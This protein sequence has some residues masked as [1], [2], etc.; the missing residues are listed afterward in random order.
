ME[1]KKKAIFTQ[2]TSR[3]AQSDRKGFE[4]I[5]KELLRVVGLVGPATKQ[6]R[7]GERWP[8]EEKP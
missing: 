3:S 8:A 6:N 7:I 5:V 1:W 4:E 2:E